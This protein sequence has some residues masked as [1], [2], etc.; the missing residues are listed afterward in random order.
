MKLDDID[1]FTAGATHGG[2]RGQNDANNKTREAI[3]ES[4]N[5]AEVTEFCADPVKGPL[6]T[7]IRMKWRQVLIRLGK[8]FP[9]S[10][11]QMGGRNHNYDFLVS[12]PPLSSA[13]EGQT[14]KIEFKY[15]TDSLTDLPQFLNLGADKPIHSQTYA[16]FFYHGDYLTRITA[17]YSIT[18]PIPSYSIYEHEVKKNSSK[19][20]FFIQ[21]KEAEALQPEHYKAKGS[22]VAESISAY[23]ESVAGST[24]LDVLTAEFQRTQND[25]VYVMYDPSTQTFTTDRIVPAELVAVSVKGVRKGN[26]LVIQTAHPTTTLEMLLRWKN[27]NGILFPA[28]QISMKRDS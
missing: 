14:V 10:I 5:S 9:R 12:Y 18:E 13:V 23:L 27:H 24:N 25:K 22:I 2:G 1:A 15:G 21:L 11:Q 4:I 3:L 20:P 19:N 17:L 7:H 28:W 6:W 26:V 16:H 8:T